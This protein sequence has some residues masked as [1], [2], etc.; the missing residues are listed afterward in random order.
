MDYGTERVPVSATGAAASA[1]GAAAVA[2]YMI[3]ATV[4]SGFEEVAAAEIREKLG[5]E[6]RPLYHDYETFKG[7]LFFRLSESAI[8]SLSRLQTVDNLYVLAPS[9]P[10][11]ELSTTQLTDP[12]TTS[13]SSSTSSASTLDSPVDGTKFPE[14]NV[15]LQPL[16]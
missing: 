8:P 14:D 15:H 3:E 5:V 16:V 6:A 2:T 11:S 9:K 13:T 1:T 10:S 12:S 4:V 7:H